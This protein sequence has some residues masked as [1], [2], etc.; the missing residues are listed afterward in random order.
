MQELNWTKPIFSWLNANFVD[1]DFRRCNICIYKT[2]LRIGIVISRKGQVLRWSLSLNLKLML[3]IK[4]FNQIS[5]IWNDA[6]LA[7][8]VSFLVSLT[9]VQRSHHLKISAR[10]FSARP[11][12][13]VADVP[14]LILP[15]SAQNHQIAIPRNNKVVSSEDFPIFI[16]R[17]LCIRSWRRTS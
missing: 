11:V 7:M 1:G 17:D 8:R 10:Q 2:V 12:R 14:A 3:K 4:G 9:C 13:C 16:P 6:R 15:E 5:Y